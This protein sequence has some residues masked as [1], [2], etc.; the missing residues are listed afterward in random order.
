MIA[1]TPLD[2]SFVKK[3]ESRDVYCFYLSSYKIS[4][5]LH[6]FVPFENKGE[7][8]ISTRDIYGECVL[9]FGS[10]SL[11]KWSQKQQQEILSILLT[12]KEKQESV[13]SKKNPGFICLKKYEK[14]L[15]KEI[16]DRV[17][18]ELSK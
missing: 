15:K 7:I 16:S 6:G 2:S 18:K 8:L 11:T 5:T 10:S 9:E 13:V 12:K 1:T 4:I 14:S 17:M 3:L